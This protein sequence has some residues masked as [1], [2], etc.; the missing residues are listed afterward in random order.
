M[1]WQGEGKAELLDRTLDLGI[2]RHSFPQPHTDKAVIFCLHFLHITV[3]ARVGRK[4]QQ[5]GDS[6]L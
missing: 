6:L 3:G 4:S 5:H 1:W 2:K